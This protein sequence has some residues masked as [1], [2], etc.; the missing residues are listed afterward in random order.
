MRRFTDRRGDRWDVVLGR[1]SWGALY[2]LFV[3]GGNAPI[4]Q[5]PLAASAY[6][7]AMQQLDAMDEQEL[8]RLLDGSQI[9]P[10]E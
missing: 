7:Q 9:K 1:E 4:R 8:Q 5:A 3:P 2:A 10:D 6:D